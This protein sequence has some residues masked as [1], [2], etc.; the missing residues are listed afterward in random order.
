MTGSW[1]NRGVLALAVLLVA[2][3][4]FRLVR[5]FDRAPL[6]RFPQAASPRG[7]T[8]LFVFQPGDCPRYRGLVAR[9]N[10]LSGDEGIRVV[11]AGL[12][13]PGDSDAR[14]RMLSRAPLEFPVRSDLAH[15]AEDLMLR[16]GYDR[17]P[18]SVLLDERGR[19]RLVLP[20]V[21]DSSVQMR[22]YRQVR[23]YAS[24]LD[25]REEDED[26]TSG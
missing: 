3:A 24:S 19:P 17:T 9:W 20:A 15:G 6:A 25:W 22:F 4:G 5:Y 2:F 14:R 11:G 10:R 7:P 26:T 13:L 21:A 8:L 18:F 1:L 16:M 23:G 12:R